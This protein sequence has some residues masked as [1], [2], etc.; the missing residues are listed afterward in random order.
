[1]D[2]DRALRSVLAMA[3]V[4]AGHEA[5]EGSN[6]FSAL[7]L[8]ERE[9]PDLILLDLA[10]PDVSGPEVLRDLRAHRATAA[11]PVIVVSA[12]PGM[13]LGSPEDL[14]IDL[15]V[16]KPF[17]LEELMEHVERLL[18]R[19]RVRATPVAPV[20]DRRK[21][22]EGPSSGSGWPSLHPF[23]ASLPVD[24]TAGEGSPREPV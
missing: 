9:R 24:P 22:A 7:R 2:D 17:D 12:R 8:A 15:L 5:I 23:R 4:D 13:L 21:A 3:L 14:G 19:P 20:V 11:I 1:M 18:A 10:L 16:S 6:G